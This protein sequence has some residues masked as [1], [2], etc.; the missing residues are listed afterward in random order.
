MLPLLHLRDLHPPRV[1]SP[2]VTSPTPF[3]SSSPPRGSASLA[4]AG[5]SRP[6]AAPS[7]PLPMTKQA[8]PTTSAEPFSVDTYRSE[9]I[10][11]GP[12]AIVVV[13]SL[14]CQLCDPQLSPELRADFN[15][16]Y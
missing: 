12:G 1:R 16:C 11:R 6:S 9:V 3:F 13:D 15:Q 7:I 5:P 10:Q 14:E 2:L 8:R 4:I